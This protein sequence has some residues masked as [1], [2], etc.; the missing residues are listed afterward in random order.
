[1]NRHT[2]TRLPEQA[3]TS[4]INVNKL[5][6]F[7]G[8]HKKIATISIPVNTD[9]DISLTYESSWIDKGLNINP[10]P[11]LVDHHTHST[12]LN[13]RGFFIVSPLYI[14]LPMMGC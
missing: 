11:K 12:E 9:T 6:V 2:I 13:S 1:M 4:G 7:I 10:W 8:H 14:S 3:M 5:N